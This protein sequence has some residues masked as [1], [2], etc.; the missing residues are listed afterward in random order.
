MNCTATSELLNTTV[1]KTNDELSQVKRNLTHTT[2][3][4]KGFLLFIE[5][6]I[7]YSVN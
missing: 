6:L 1:K 3:A 2:N 5:E 4:L 7:K